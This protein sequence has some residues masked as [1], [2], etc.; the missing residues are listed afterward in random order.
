[1]NACI[2]KLI[3]EKYDLIIIL[4][5]VRTS[6]LTALIPQKVNKV[7]GETIWNLSSDHSVT[8][9]SKVARDSDLDT[10]RSDHKRKDLIPSGKYAVKK[11][12]FDVDPLDPTGGKVC[13]IN[14]Y[15][16]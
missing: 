3:T 5:Y 7:T 9:L 15:F 16:I 2:N 10:S 6:S 11:K 13:T 12:R 1:M 8:K 14:A 4:F